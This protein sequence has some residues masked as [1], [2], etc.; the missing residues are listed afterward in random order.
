MPPKKKEEY[1]QIIPLY[2][3]DTQTIFW[4]FKKFSSEECQNIDSFFTNYT[5]E[6]NV[7]M[8]ENIYD[9]MQFLSKSIGNQ[10]HPL[11]IKNKTNQQ[12]NLSQQQTQLEKEKDQ[13]QKT[14]KKEEIQKQMQQPTQN[15]ELINFQEE[16]PPYFQI[17]NV[18]IDYETMKMFLVSIQSTNII[19]LKF[20]NNDFDEETLRLLIQFLNSE[21]KIKRLFF[22][23][24]SIENLNY[25]KEFFE[26]IGK[27]NKIENLIL[28]CN[29][30]KGELTQVIAQSIE[31]NEQSSLKFIDLYDNQIDDLGFIS[32]GNLIFKNRS[33]EVIGLAK[34]NITNVNQLEKIFYSIGMHP[35]TEQEYIEYRNKE[36]ERDQII[37][38]NKKLK[39]KKIADA[40]KVPILEPI[41]QISDNSIKIFQQNIYYQ[42]KYGSMQEIINQTCLIY[43]QIRQKEMIMFKNLINFFLK[44]KRSSN[45]YCCIIYL[46]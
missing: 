45:Q 24:N 26:N 44:H 35:L 32:L 37:E 11:F 29:N 17:C 15:L 30:L 18:K 12:E 31:N 43:H 3:Q 16:L 21:N 7:K 25:R 2:Q 36:Q 27:L 22:E 4:K 6:I 42:K 1:K 23:W 19:T 9:N 40:E 10:L 8:T 20:S 41:Q 33:L 46:Q 34:N 38:R 13:T 28:R 39:G 5:K 14:L